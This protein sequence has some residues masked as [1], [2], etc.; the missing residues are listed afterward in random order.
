MKRT[1]TEQNMEGSNITGKSVEMISNAIAEMRTY[2]EGFIIADQSPNA[3]DISAIRNTNTK[4]I[5]RL[6]DED[7]RQLAGRAAALRDEQLDEIAK[8]P[9]GVAVVYQNDW[10]EPVLCKIHKYE[11]E[12]TVYQYMD[13]EFGREQKQEQW[14]KEELLKL[15][16]KGRVNEKI[17]VDIDK[18][19]QQ[20]LSVN[21]S[22]KLKRT[23]RGLLDEYQKNEKLDL[24]EDKNFA[25]LSVLVEELMH[26]RNKVEQAALT[27]GD[28]VDFDCRLKE[29][30]QQQYPDVSAEICLTL[31]QCLMKQ[32]SVE[33]AANNE[34]Y[35]AWRDTVLKRGGQQC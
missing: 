4:I 29:L 35:A 23:I 12:E 24:W 34:I 17:D 26:C 5:M 30:V 33:G 27:A 32:Y 20:V 25:S 13:K 3:I 8:L 11:G 6:P 21:L 18:L 7:D 19:Q 1:S 28:Y 31:S 9:K 10:L 22:T 15:L 2:G 14:F 16:V